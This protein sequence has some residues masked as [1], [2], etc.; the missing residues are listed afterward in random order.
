M[1]ALALQVVRGAAAEAKMRCCR[2]GGRWLMVV[3]LCSV[4]HCCIATCKQSRAEGTGSKA[5]PAWSFASAARHVASNQR[6]PGLDYVLAC[7]VNRVISRLCVPRGSCVLRAAAGTVRFC[8]IVFQV[9]DICQSGRYAVPRNARS[10]QQPNLKQ[11]LSAV[12][13][14]EKV[15]LCMPLLQSVRPLV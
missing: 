8:Q 1:A 11:G 9:K 3:P 5:E 12:Q 15:G 13:C 6:L 10:L 14:M 2:W 7:A 4:L